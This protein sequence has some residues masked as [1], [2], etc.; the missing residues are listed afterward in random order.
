[1]KSFYAF[2]LSTIIL[3]AISN[4][5]AA[6]N[7][8]G[9]VAMSRYLGGS[10]SDAGLHMTVQGNYIYAWGYSAS[11]NYPVTMGAAFHSGPS[12]FVVTKM[13]LNGN[14]IYS[15][16]IGGTALESPANVN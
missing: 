3:I 6:Q 13:D 11:A 14:V 5:L 8:P 9:Y 15:R 2:F 12:D 10:L 4:N 7:T 16:Y 1:M